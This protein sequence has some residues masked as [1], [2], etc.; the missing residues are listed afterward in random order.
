MSKVNENREQQRME[1][2]RMEK[3]VQQEA[4][5][6]SDDFSKLVGQKQEQVAK[7]NSAEQ[8]QK[9][10]A[11]KHQGTQTRMKAG[12]ALLARQ[13]IQANKFQQAMAQQGQQNLQ[14]TKGETTHR[15]SE[16][17]EVRDFQTQQEQV[18]ERKEADKHE[19][20]QAIDHDEGEA[21]TGAGGG[22]DFGGDGSQEGSP[23]DSQL[24]GVG[25]AGEA[26]ATAAGTDVAGA[27]GPRLPP[28]V[29][30]KIVKQV[31]VGKNQQGLGEIHIDFKGSELD[32]TSMVLTSEG[33]KIYA[34]VFTDN[35]NL[36][37]LFKASHTELSRAMRDGAN[38]SLESL[39][40]IGAV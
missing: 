31:L 1:Q 16:H 12:N 17:H 15:T 10:E 34:K 26:N 38:L 29:L 4:R 32:G 19:R 27:A 37:R 6:K 13:G 28:E 11:V 9:G 20:V 18:R 8:R 23:R 14:Q 36:G 30:Q 24:Q 2:A 25:Q 40:V 33:S 22:G 21:Q 7:N 5:Q 3:R 35:R 39:E